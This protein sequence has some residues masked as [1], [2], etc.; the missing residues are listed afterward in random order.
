MKVIQFA[1]VAVVPLFAGFLLAQEPRTETQTT[2]TTTWNGTLLDAGCRSTHTESKETKSDENGTKSKTTH[3]ETTDCPVVTTT[4][5]FGLLTPEGK[6]IHFDSAGNTR[7]VEMMKKDKKWSRE[8]SE[9][10][11]V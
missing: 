5:S 11:P 9:R 3:T 10:A 2:T 1:A 4:T 8:V 7:I 6:Y